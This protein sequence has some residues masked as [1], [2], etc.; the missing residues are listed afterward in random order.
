MIDR[1]EFCGNSCININDDS[2]LLR[3]ANQLSVTPAQLFAA[4]CAVGTSAR[5]VIQYLG[6]LS[7]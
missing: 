1:D 7:A 2:D 4:V 5:L 3:W 6:S